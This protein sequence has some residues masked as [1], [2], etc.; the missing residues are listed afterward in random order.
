MADAIFE[1]DAYPSAS[2]FFFL[3]LRRVGGRIRGSAVRRGRCWC[4]S[5]CW[6]LVW[7]CSGLTAAAFTAHHRARGKGI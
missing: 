4:W 2:N 6:C 5:W 7:W 3:D 1:K